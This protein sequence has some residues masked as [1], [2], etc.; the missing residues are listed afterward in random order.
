MADE[1]GNPKLTLR[2]L[3]AQTALERWFDLG[4]A[5]L[6]LN[7]DTGGWEGGEFIQYTDKPAAE[8]CRIYQHRRRR[9]KTLRA[10]EVFEVVPRE[11][12]PAELPR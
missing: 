12:W 4:E 7:P 5:V 1:F 6:W 9:H 11:K 10:G 2:L 3:G 8:Y